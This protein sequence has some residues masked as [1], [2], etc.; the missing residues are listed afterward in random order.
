[1]VSMVNSSICCLLLFSIYFIVWLLIMEKLDDKEKNLENEAY[2]EITQEKITNCRT[3]NFIRIK[4]NH[5][6]GNRR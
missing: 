5:I 4:L 1:M 2:P 6:N 3:I